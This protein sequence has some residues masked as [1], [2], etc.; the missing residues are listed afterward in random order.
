MAKIG[1]KV[2]Q[3]GVIQ[4]EAKFWLDPIFRD[5]LTSIDLISK[6]KVK[7]IIGFDRAH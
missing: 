4:R 7:V 2:M 6:I 5:L 3:Y 1:I